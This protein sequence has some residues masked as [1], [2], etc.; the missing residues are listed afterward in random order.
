M[1]HFACKLRL[2][3]IRNID[4]TGDV[5]IPLEIGGSLGIAGNGCPLSGSRIQEG[6]PFGDHR[7]SVTSVETEDQ[8]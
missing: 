3:R 4:S 8:L 2:N 5:C 6:N 1:A 7:T